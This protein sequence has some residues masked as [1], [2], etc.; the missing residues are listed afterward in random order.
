M[1]V[2]PA[3][4]IVAADVGVGGDERG[5]RRRDLLALLALAVLEHHQ[6]ALV[7]HHAADLEALG[8]GEVGE[9]AGVGR[10]AAAAG[11]ADVDVDRGSAGCR[12]AAAAAIVASLSTAT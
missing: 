1:P 6:V 8:A 7:A 5:H 2:P 10:V 11:Q 4:M 9:A 12:R 3:E